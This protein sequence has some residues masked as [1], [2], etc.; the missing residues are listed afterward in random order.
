MANHNHCNANSTDHN[1]S[2]IK[3]LTLKRKQK[4]LKAELEQSLCKTV[5]F[6]EAFQNEMD[7]RTKLDEKHENLRVRYDVSRWFY[8]IFDP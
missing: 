5:S 7:L 4:E 1:N 8:E 6:K 2:S 3:I